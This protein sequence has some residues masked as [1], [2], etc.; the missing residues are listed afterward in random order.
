MRCS[1]IRRFAAGRFLRAAS[2][3]SDAAILQDMAAKKIKL[4]QLESLL[5]PDFERA[6]RLRRE[7]VC[8]YM[9]QHGEP[10][11]STAPGNSQF[12]SGPC[13]PCALHAA[14]VGSRIMVFS[15]PHDN[16]PTPFS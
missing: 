7:F 12:R 6:V 5:K 13:P 10:R 9:A 16:A 15:G 2:D 11:Y 14:Q 1:S 3:L 8:N 4:H